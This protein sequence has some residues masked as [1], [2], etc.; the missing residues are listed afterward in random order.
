MFQS[1]IWELN[2]Y[3]ILNNSFLV[4]IAFK[5]IF[6]LLM[7]FSQSHL[8]RW[9]SWPC[10]GIKTEIIKLQSN[11]RKNHF[12]LFW[13]SKH[14]NNYI[15]VYWLCYML[16]FLSYNSEWAGQSVGAQL[17][18]EGDDSGVIL[19]QIWKGKFHF[20]ANKMVKYTAYFMPPISTILQ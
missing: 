7:R 14:H 10:T 18:P 19:L 1:F 6:R 3:F 5:L 9:L 2:A 20:A 16:R 15:T 12:T 8:A 4:L 11:S 17:S 13:L